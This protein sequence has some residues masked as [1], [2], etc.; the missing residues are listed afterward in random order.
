MPMIIKKD[1]RRN[2]DDLSVGSGLEEK[3]HHGGQRLCEHL[4]E[5]I[6]CSTIHFLISSQSCF[7]CSFIQGDDDD[8]AF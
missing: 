4:I 2:F 5:I 7:L 3:G 6:C 8:G 1:V